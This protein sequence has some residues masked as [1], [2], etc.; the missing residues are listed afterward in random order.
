MSKSQLLTWCFL[1]DVSTAVWQQQ[2]IVWSR[3]WKSKISISQSQRAEN[4]RRHIDLEG[5]LFV[6][7]SFTTPSLWSHLNELLLGVL[8]ATQLTL[9]ALSQLS[10]SVGLLFSSGDL[11]P[12]LLLQVLLLHGY[13]AVLLL[14]LLQPAETKRDQTG[15]ESQRAADK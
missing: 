5:I 2:L 4:L 13:S 11:I 15:L 6:L 14:G 1:N 10:Q 12:H 3:V 9:G 8:E 7:P